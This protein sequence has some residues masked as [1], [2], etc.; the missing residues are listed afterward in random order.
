MG[1]EEIKNQV[2]RAEVD[3][4]RQIGSVNLIAVSKV[5]PLQKVENTLIKGHR[6]FGEIVLS[7][8]LMSVVCHR[9]HL[10]LLILS[11]FFLIQII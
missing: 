6:V 7:N 10:N 8:T 9:G 1:L 3:S 2:K 4:G 5:Q 11:K